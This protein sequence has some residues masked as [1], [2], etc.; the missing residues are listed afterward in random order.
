M[1]S[2][3]CLVVLLIGLSASAAVGQ[4]VSTNKC[5]EHAC[6]ASYPEPDDKT[7]AVGGYYEPL[8]QAPIAVAHALQLPC[9]N[10]F[11]VMVGRQRCHLNWISACWLFSNAPV[12][13]LT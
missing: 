3:R 12:L 10:K 7:K 5:R 13:T 1:A 4:V 9:G 2:T 6:M 11:L 8:G